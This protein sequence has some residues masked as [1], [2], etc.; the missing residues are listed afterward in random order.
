MQRYKALWYNLTDKHVIDGIVNI[1]IGKRDRGTLK[2]LCYV[3]VRMG[4][5]YCEVVDMQQAH[6][7]F[8]KDID[9]LVS[10]YE[11]FVAWKRASF[12][13]ASHDGLSRREE[14]DI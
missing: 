9:S 10:K 1:A 4:A 12:K 3:S 2:D 8:K 14:R 7:T 6:E 5:K 11:G 13:N